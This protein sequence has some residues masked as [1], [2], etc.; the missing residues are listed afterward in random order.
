[1]WKTIFPQIEEEGDVLGMIQ[2]HYIYWAL[3]F[4]YYSISSTSDHQAL[5]SGVWGGLEDLTVSESVGRVEAESAA[6]ACPEGL[7]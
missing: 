7:T 6:F 4:Y 3:Y 1:M 2:A 5:D